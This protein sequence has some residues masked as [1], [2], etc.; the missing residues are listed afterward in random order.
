M[1]SMSSENPLKIVDVN[2][3]NNPTPINN[4]EMPGP[5]MQTFSNEA[6]RIT[7]LGILKKQQTNCTAQSD[8]LTMTYTNNGDTNKY[9]NKED[10]V[11]NVVL[12]AHFHQNTT[13]NNLLASNANNA[14]GNYKIG[15][16]S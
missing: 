4:A 11:S 1:L 10:T 6:A 5:S 3:F 8:S 2:L 12:V 15:G 14:S 9:T 13:H 7:Q 16:S